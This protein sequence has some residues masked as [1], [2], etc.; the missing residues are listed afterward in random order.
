[1]PRLSKGKRPVRGGAAGFSAIPVWQP[2]VAV[3]GR[4]WGYDG[5]GSLLDSAI[6][7]FIVVSQCAAVIPHDAAHIH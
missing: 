7:I 3:T 1:M 2:V 6:S 4:D 5:L